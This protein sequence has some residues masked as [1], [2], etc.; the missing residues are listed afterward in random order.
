MLNNGNTNAT[1]ESSN[2]KDKIKRKRRPH[3]ANEMQV[4]LARPSLQRKDDETSIE[5]KTNSSNSN[6][7]FVGKPSLKQPSRNSSK[8]SLKKAEIIK[9]FA[10]ERHPGLPAVNNRQK[11][12]NKTSKPDY[13]D[14]GTYVC[15]DSEDGSDQSDFEF[16]DY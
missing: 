8:A 9:P 13:V 3:P 2:K 15:F 5:E 16:L 14:V 1:I 4:G 12:E 6:R 10:K 7:G 11:T